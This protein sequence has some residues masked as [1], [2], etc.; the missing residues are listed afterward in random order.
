M[1]KIW[2]AILVLILGGVVWFVGFS[3]E[4]FFST[5]NV[6]NEVVLQTNFGDIKIRLYRDEVP[7]IAEN[8]A[9]LVANKKYDGNIFHRVIKGF[10]IQGGDFENKNGTGGYPFGMK[11]GES[12]P[13]EISNKLTHDRGAVS[14]ANRGANTNGSQFF[15]IQKTARHLDGKYSIFGQVI[16]GMEVVDKIAE[17]ETDLN[18]FPLK[19][20]IIEKAYFLES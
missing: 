19:E 10:M 6:Q 13:D 5:K 11:A 2:W 16:E 20:V 3:Q 18:N 15:I 8:F 4:N 14:M 7:K 1:K 12:L 17:T 9:Q